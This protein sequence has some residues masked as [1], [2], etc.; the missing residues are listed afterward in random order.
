MRLIPWVAALALPV[1]AAAQ[2]PTGDAI[3]A[4]VDANIGSD[5]KVTLARM[6]VEGRGVTRTVESRS[7]IRG[8]TESF[9]EYLAPPRDRGTKMLKLGDQLWTYFPESDRTI[10]ISGHMLRQSVMGSDLSYEDLMEDPRLGAL[11]TA[12]VVGEETHRDRPCWVLE[13]T[14]KAPGIAYQSRRMWVDKARDVALR[15]DRFAKGGKLLKTTDVLTV[16]RIGGRWVAKTVVFKNVL[17]S[18]QG[19]RFE[20]ETIEFN[21]SIPE[22][23]FSKAMLRR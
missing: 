4:R 6:V 11:Y 19:T 9:T 16:E 21:A 10:R 7:W 8:M 3:L 22:H 13:L 23:V 18:G 5:S 20:L 1:L 14:A 15:E 12:T 17:K 2:A